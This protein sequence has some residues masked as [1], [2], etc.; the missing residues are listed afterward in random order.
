[1]LVSVLL[2]VTILRIEKQFLGGKAL[3][4]PSDCLITICFVFKANLIIDFL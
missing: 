3:N 4:I 1:M 2:V